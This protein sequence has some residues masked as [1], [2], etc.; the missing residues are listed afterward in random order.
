[1]TLPDAD[2]NVGKSVAAAQLA[3]LAS[4]MEGRVDTVSLSDVVD[5]LG[6]AG[7]GM[8]ILMLS[9]PAL[10][11]IPGP[12]GFVFG[13]LVAL[14]ALKLMLGAKWIM[15]P[16]FAR[17]WLPPAKAVR[18]FAVKGSRSC[19]WYRHGCDRVAGLCSPAKPGAWH[20]A[21]RSCWWVSRLPCPS[22]RATFLPYQ[23]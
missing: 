12:V 19:E 16:D 13:L 23:A 9:L 1:M 20:W 21:C 10:I 17:Q 6:H 15:L 3:T 5:G 11:P 8:M 22:Q 2:S 4:R 7:I 18:S 14:V